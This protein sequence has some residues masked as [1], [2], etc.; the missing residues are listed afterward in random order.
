MISF[1][2]LS[3][4][5]S[6]CGDSSGSDSGGGSS[7]SSGCGGS[8]NGGSGTSVSYGN[9]GGG[10]I[11]T[12]NNCGGGYTGSGPSY[13]SSGCGGENSEPIYGAP[14]DYTSRATYTNQLENINSK[15]TSYGDITLGV[16]LNLVGCIGF[17]I[18]FGILINLDNATQSGIFFTGGF[19]AGTS[20]GASV[21]AGYTPGKFL[22]E[23]A[24][25][26]SLGLGSIGGNIGFSS[27]GTISSGISGSLPIGIDAG[28]NISKQYGFVIPFDTPE[29]R[30]K[31]M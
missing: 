6:D 19:A 9:C 31:S 22:D 4:I 20:A 11:P 2:C 15:N 13:T 25:T 3:R 12:S 21:F 5:G 28:F 17:D 8:F 24:A 27:D 16:N 23:N 1:F 30:E 7:S 29:Q 26:L 10:T 14:A 18:S